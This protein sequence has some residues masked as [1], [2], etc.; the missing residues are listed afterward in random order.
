MSF[1]S[2]IGDAISSVTGFF[3]DT[4]GE[5]FL[6]DAIGFGAGLL[7]PSGGGGGSGGMLNLATDAYRPRRFEEGSPKDA[8]KTAFPESEDMQGFMDD[9]IF[10]TKRFAFLTEAVSTK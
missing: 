8:T 4:F 2:A 6:G 9:W 5:G 7:A 10:R 1:F 3:N